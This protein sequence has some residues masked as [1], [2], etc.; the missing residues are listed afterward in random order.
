[1]RNTK[2]RGGLGL[3]WFE[4]KMDL[5]RCGVGLRMVWGR[6]GFGLAMVCG[7]VL[8]RLFIDFSNFLARAGLGVG[9][10]YHAPSQKVALVLAKLLVLV[11]RLGEP[12]VCAPCVTRLRYVIQISGHASWAW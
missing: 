4:F 9:S 2:A 5:N 10:E 7:G 6:F 8:A 12:A 3:F 1:M 11:S